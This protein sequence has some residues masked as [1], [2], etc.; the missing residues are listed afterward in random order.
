MR[1]LT[2]LVALALAAA[3]AAQAQPASPPKIPPAQAAKPAPVAPA[4]P[5]GV[6]PPS[7]SLLPNSAADDAQAQCSA[8]CSRTYYMCLT[9]D[10]ADLCSG[11]WAQCR[12]RC[13]NTAR[14]SGP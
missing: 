8:T 11:E 13:G 2:V 7:R 5:M 1:R 3:V 14:R 6:T 4:P 9:G 10:N 12:V